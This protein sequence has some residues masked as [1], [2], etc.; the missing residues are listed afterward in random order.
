M[1]AE[2]KYARGKVVSKMSTI[3]REML[4]S[5][6]GH[7]DV[8]NVAA[9][10]WVLTDVAND[11]LETAI[12]II[13]NY[14]DL[15]EWKRRSWLIRVYLGTTVTRIGYIDVDSGETMYRDFLTWRLGKEFLDSRHRNAIPAWD[16][17]VDYY[18]FDRLA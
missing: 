11:D 6:L 13:K 9:A 14:Y 18:G 7:P 4:D 5:N 8:M 3:N 17:T 2:A 16:A 12:A 10:A 1:R 15:P